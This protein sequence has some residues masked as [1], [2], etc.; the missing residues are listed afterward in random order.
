MLYHVF[1]EV[2]DIPGATKNLSLYE[3][4]KENTNKI[5]EEI[6][7][8]YLQKEE[9]Q[10]SGYFLK[11]QNIVRIQVKTTEFPIKSIVNLIDSQTPSNVAWFVTKEDAFVDDVYTQDVTTEIIKEAKVRMQEPL[12]LSA[13][14]SSTEID[15]KKVFIV[16]GHDESVKIAVARFL[17]R[18]D[19]QPIILHEQASGGTTIIEKIE[20]NTDVGFGIVLYTPCDLGKAK[21]DD[22]L[23]I[24]AR[25]NV[26]F[27][28]GY[29]IAKLGRSNVCALVKDNI[30]KPNDISGVVYVNYDSGTSWHM[31]LFKELKNAGY[32]LDA[33][34]LFL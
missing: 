24:R 15:N 7:L 32:D 21:N 27:E 3:Y 17:E 11:A 16:H 28:H 5:I 13:S 20:N 34:K 12:K 9:L 29:L 8:P 31:E 6:I 26:I 25:Q 10:F 18:L 22:E 1:M 30:E 2:T 14:P 33:N 4:D 23:Q 19:L